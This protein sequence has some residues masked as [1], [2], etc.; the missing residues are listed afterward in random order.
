MATTTAAIQDD[1]EHI[2][3]DGTFSVIS[4]PSEDDAPGPSRDRSAAP[5]LGS[6]SD[7]LD[8]PA[9]PLQPN[10]HTRNDTHSRDTNGELGEDHAVE[11]YGMDMTDVAEPDTPRAQSEDTV[12]NDS[13]FEAL[14][15]TTNFLA[16]LLYEILC[17]P[18]FRGQIYGVA[19]EIKTECVALSS[20]IG[21]LGD[22][23][24][25]YAKHKSIESRLTELPLGLPG[26]LESL[27]TELLS[28]QE[29]LNDPGIRGSYSTI[30]PRAPRSS[31]IIGYYE[32]IKTFSSQM[33]GLMAVVQTDYANFHTL[34]MP[35]VLA[36]ETDSCTTNRSG[37]R[38]SFNRVA[39]GNNNLSHLRRELYT[40]KDQIV[41]C[42][43]EIHSYEQHGMPN[44]PDYGKKMATLVVSYRQTKE[45]LELMLSNH[46][47]DWID[48]SIAGGL[49][50][51]EFC[52]LNPDTI[53]SLILQLKEVTDDLF[54]E[55]S[56]AQRYPPRNTRIDDLAIGESSIHTLCAI[57]E[58]LVSILHLQSRT[59]A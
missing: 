18:C 59:Q 20:H 29:T 27:K 33:D 28:M 41:A 34:H 24:G 12:N 14:C 31:W 26:W 21:R 55:R 51:P 19:S 11:R 58:V 43:S 3:D 35:L 46:G 52:R 37:H 30:L 23:L 32:N 15:E 36:S 38:R 40:L 8:H 56:R 4:L 1:W 45:S 53:R 57:E 5:A 50:Y 7:N 22:I 25:G 9:H 16:K 54:L 17:D 49:T 6:L 42:L 10:T 39:S 48:Y 44:D 47:S 2:D 13:G